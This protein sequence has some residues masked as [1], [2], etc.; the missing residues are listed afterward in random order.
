MFTKIL[1]KK[2]LIIWFLFTCLRTF[3]FDFVKLCTER[4][5]I[6]SAATA[7]TAGQPGKWV[8]VRS[9]KQNHGWDI[10]K[11]YFGMALLII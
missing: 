5:L 1:A 6:L 10:A 9:K 4:G 11:K 8:E 7:L 3:V 2:G